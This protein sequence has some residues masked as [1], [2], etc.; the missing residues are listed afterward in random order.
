[1]GE[2]W[3]FAYVLPQEKGEEVRLVVPN[4]LQ[5]CWIESPPYFCADSETARDVAQKYV[6][7]PVGTFPNHKFVKHYA[8][9]DDFESLPDTGSEKLH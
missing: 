5:M 3:N 1:M 9:G 8:Q 6:Q 7:T 2:K 4:S